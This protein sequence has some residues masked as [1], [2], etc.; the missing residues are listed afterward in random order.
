MH[1]QDIGFGRAD[2]TWAKDKATQGQEAQGFRLHIEDDVVFQRGAVN[3][4]TGPTGS[5]KTSVLMALLGEMHLVPLN[6]ASWVSLPKDGGVAYASQ[7]SWV[8]NATIKVSRQ[9]LDHI[10]GAE[11]LQENIL[12]DN[13]YDGA[14]YKKGS[15]FVS[16]DYSYLNDCNSSPSM[17]LK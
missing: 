8:L 9:N 12:L 2:F 14:R 16:A 6:Q 1:N 11:H 10:L 5:G 3:L 13:L 17:R 15:G 7:E 4:I